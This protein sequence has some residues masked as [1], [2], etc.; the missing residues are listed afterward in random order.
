MLDWNSIR[1]IPPIL[2]I[3]YPHAFYYVMKILTVPIKVV[4]PV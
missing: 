1:L 2:I 3:R 4:F